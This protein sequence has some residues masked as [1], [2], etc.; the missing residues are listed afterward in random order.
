MTEPGKAAP[1]G[2][3]TTAVRRFLQ[4]FAAL[5]AADWAAAARAF[6]AAERTPRFRR[7]DVALGEAITRAGRD[8][9]R[10]AALRPLLQIVHAAPEDGD[11]DGD[12]PTLDPVAPAAAAAVLALVAR[13]VLPPDAFAALYAPI[14]PLV[15][16]DALG[17][18]PVS[19]PAP[20]A[21]GSAG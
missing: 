5:S 20:P 3:N 11:D 17:A 19:P 15:P 13:D 10:D 8:A 16:L 1:Y 2:P 12:A 18:W 6:D 21:A 14:A 4:R 7:A 9:E